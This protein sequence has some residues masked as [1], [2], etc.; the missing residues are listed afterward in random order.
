MKLVTQFS[1]FLVNK[2]GVLARVLSDIA[3]AK[4]NMI[5]MTMADTTEHGVLR[6]VIAKPEQARQVLKQ[7][8]VPVTETDVL[9]LDLPNRPGAMADVCNRLAAEH[10]NIAYAYAT[11]GAAGGRTTGIIK[12]ADMAKAMKV[13]QQAAPKRR[14]ATGLG[15][16]PR[17]RT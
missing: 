14:T 12:V 1:V 11:S 17:V 3:R 13:L 10:I 9:A 4:L 16:R 8:G 15:R 5:A 2:P 7:L 6:L